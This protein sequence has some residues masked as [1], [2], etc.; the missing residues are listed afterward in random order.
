MYLA[1]IGSLGGRSIHG[2]HMTKM[3]YFVALVRFRRNS[4]PPELRVRYTSRD[5][6]W[7]GS[8]YP[9]NTNIFLG[10]FLVSSHVVIVFF[11]FSQIG[12]L[13]NQYC[14]ARVESVEYGIP[15]HN[16]VFIVFGT[17]AL[18]RTSRLCIYTGRAISRPIPILI[19]I[20]MK[21]SR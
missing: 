9:S 7:T 2:S 19:N 1:V 15:S 11:I 20:R 6:I 17:D 21:V 8:F 13:D 16:W 4:S 5:K 10:L 18:L 12:R 14:K 3:V